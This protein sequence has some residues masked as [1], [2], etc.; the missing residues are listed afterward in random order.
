MEDEYKTFVHVADHVFSL[1]IH[2]CVYVDTHA[3]THTHV[4]MY[5]KVCK[6]TKFS[7]SQRAK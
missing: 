1:I 7:E 3:H 2:I 4:C 6:G 5:A